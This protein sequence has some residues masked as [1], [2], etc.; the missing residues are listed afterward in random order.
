MEV[1][2][3]GLIVGSTRQQMTLLAEFETA[4]A[5]S[6]PSDDPTRKSD[7]EPVYQKYLT[8]PGVNE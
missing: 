1:N 8:L 2:N 4:D 3:K 7:T 6:L 5:P